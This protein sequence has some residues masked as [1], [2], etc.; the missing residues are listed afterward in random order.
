MRE[1]RRLPDARRGPADARAMG[2]SG[3]SSRGDRH[4]PVRLARGT[5][6]RCS[7]RWSTRC[8]RSGTQGA[9]AAARPCCTAPSS[10]C[11]P[12]ARRRSRGS[13]AR[14][15]GQRVVGAITCR[16]GG[17]APR[18]GR[19]RGTRDPARKPAT[20]C[21]CAQQLTGG[22]ALQHGRCLAVLF[23]RGPRCA[24][25]WRGASTTTRDGER[26]RRRRGGSGRGGVTGSRRCRLQLVCRTVSTRASVLAVRAPDG[27]DAPGRRGREGEPDSVAEAAGSFHSRAWP[28]SV[29]TI[30][31]SA[32]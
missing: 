5:H 11:R 1:S 22:R 10:S 26:V 18:P 8:G 2:R 16:A 4:W 6:H 13:C 27:G 24:Q 7:S 28:T 14:D 32:A 25:G 9:R 20:T 12:R 15:G 29:S 3:A 17:C 31:A 21:C 23:P 30:D 19:P